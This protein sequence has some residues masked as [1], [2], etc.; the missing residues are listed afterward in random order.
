M[1]AVDLCIEATAIITGFLTPPQATF[2]WR[3][4]LCQSIH[5]AGHSDALKNFGAF[6]AFRHHQNNKL[7]IRQ[8]L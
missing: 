3:S 8:V 2:R 7:D 5:S 6:L 1:G 4:A